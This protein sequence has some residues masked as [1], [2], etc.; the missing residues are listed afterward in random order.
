MWWKLSRIVILSFVLVMGLVAVAVAQGMMG[1]G[2]NQGQSMGSNGS[3]SGTG[4]GGSNGTMSGNPMTS[5]QRGS[6][7]GMGSDRS[8]NGAAMGMSTS[9][10]TIGAN[11]TLY[12]LSG[13]TAQSAQTTG[14]IDTTKLSALSGTTG[15][16]LWSIVF[17]ESS[18]TKPVEGPDGMLFLVALSSTDMGQG[19]MSGTTTSLN[20]DSKL[21]IVNPSTRKI[22]TVTL[23]GVIA[24]APLIGGTGSN[25]LVYI[26]TFD[27]GSGSSGSSAQGMLSAAT[28]YAFAEDG[29]LK[30]KIS[31]DQ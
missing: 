7:V 18:L 13:S 24:S 29:S 9:A 28:L 22:T 27:L 25:Y 23:A 15:N 17:N 26:Q 19:G 2:S 12:I 1:S 31:L 5:G 10:L 3:M 21:Y 8:I 4:N 16:T 20:T 6:G 11:G 30:F 14:S